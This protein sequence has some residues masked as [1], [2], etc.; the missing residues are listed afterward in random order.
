M[1]IFPCSKMSENDIKASS[2]AITRLSI[3]LLGFW[4]GWWGGEL[5]YLLNYYHIAPSYVQV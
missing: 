2:I 1:D 5:D 3:I 4:L